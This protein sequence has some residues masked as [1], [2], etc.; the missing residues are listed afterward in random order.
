MGWGGTYSLFLVL[1][2]S[3]KQAKGGLGLYDILLMLSILHG[4]IYQNPRN[5][6]CVAH[7]FQVMQGL[8]HQPSDSRPQPSVPHPGLEGWP[9]GRGS[10]ESYC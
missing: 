5:P 1:G 2:I 3:R 7:I 9:T 6:F 4:L 10:S 8:F